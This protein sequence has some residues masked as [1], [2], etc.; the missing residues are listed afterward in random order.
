VTDRTIANGVLL[1]QYHAGVVFCVLSLEYEENAGSES[2]GLSGGLQ[3]I[4]S[5]IKKGLT[6]GEATSP[7]PST[8]STPSNPRRLGDKV[9]LYNNFS[10]R[11]IHWR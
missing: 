6:R 10:N 2:G 9:W 3:W 4:A 8:P 7:A 5:S 11:D 1:A